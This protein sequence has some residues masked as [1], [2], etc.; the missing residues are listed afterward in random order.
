MSALPTALF[1]T[2]QS[3]FGPVLP[4]DLNAETVC[5]LDFSA[6]NAL[7]ENQNLENTK[8]FAAFVNKMLAQ[9]QATV[10]I[11]GYLENR[12][13]YRRS[14]LFAGE[15]SDRQIHLGVDIWVEAGTPVLAPMDGII[16]SFKDNAFFGDYGP[17]II[18]EHTIANFKFFTLFGHLNRQSLLHLHA[19]DFFMKGQAIGAVGSYPENGDWP[20]H[21]HFQVITDMLGQHG[22]FPGVCSLTDQKKYAQLCPDPNL[23][24]QCRHVTAF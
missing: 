16:H 13:I 4:L 6:Q 15:T 11:G 21:L 9:Q 8:Q 18:L 23:I 10:G 3:L 24:L 7:L 5:R 2:Y 12:V 20:P 22:D 17:T 19:G 1:T 14:R